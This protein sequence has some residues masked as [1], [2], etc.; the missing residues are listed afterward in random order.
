M[1]MRFILQRLQRPGPDCNSYYHEL[2]LRG[3]PELTQLMARLINPGKRSH[4]PDEEPNFYDIAKRFPL[5]EITYD[6]DALIGGHP[7]VPREPE[8]NASLAYFNE[9][10]RVELTSHDR[11]VSGERDANH[12]RREHYSYARNPSAYHPEYA[13]RYPQDNRG[14]WHHSY[15]QNYGHTL[16]PYSY[17]QQAN[18]NHFFDPHMYS[19]Y[20]E[21]NAHWH[22]YGESTQGSNPWEQ[23]ASRPHSSPSTQTMNYRSFAED[24]SQPSNR[25]FRPE[26]NQGFESSQTASVAAS[27]TDG[28]DI[29]SPS[30]NSQFSQ[31]SDEKGQG[32]NSA[33]SSHGLEPAANEDTI[34][35]SE[36]FDLYQVS[37]YN[38]EPYWM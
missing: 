38:N 15:P 29:M 32:H 7:M 13:S 4:D 6:D 31:F 35:E 18:Q 25:H 5:P 16:G 19:G 12:R 34:N 9:H 20:R 37:T 10:T 1:C 8:P 36:T 27:L 33:F 30:E 14:Y 23:Y 21:N 11:Y 28:N 22:H 17:D 26:F 2:F 3:R 24:V